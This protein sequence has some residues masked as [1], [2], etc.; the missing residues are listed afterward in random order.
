MG[1]HFL[2]VLS[3]TRFTIMSW[4]QGIPCWRII[5]LLISLVRVISSFGAK[6]N[7]SFQCMNGDL[8]ILNILFIS[9]FKDATTLLK[10]QKGKHSFPVSFEILRYSSSKL[11]FNEVRVQNDIFFIIRRYRIF[12]IGL[13]SK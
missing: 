7:V 4:F 8:T 10:R 2:L 12:L 13:L 1:I 5:R 9:N 11:W 3:Q 6:I